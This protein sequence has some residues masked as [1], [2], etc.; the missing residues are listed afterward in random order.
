MV[1][2]IFAY[3]C[4]AV[5]FFSS[6]KKD[7]SSVFSKPPQERVAETLTALDKTLTSGDGWVM[8]VFTQLN[9][10]GYSFYC[11]FKD[12]NRVNMLSD[13][14][15]QTVTVIKQ[16]SYRT[17]WMQQPSLIFDTYNYL[18]LLSDPMPSEGNVGGSAG[19]GLV[20]DF[21]F[22]L[23]AETVDSL[24]NFPDKLTQLITIGRYNQLNVRF[25]KLSAASADF[26][27]QGKMKDFIADVQSFIESHAVNGVVLSSNKMQMDFGD[28][29]I[30]FTW[31]EGDSVKSKGMGFAYGDNKIVLED[32]I[33]FGGEKFTQFIWDS[34]KLY[35]VSTTNSVQVV[36]LGAPIIPV[37]LAIDKGVIEEIDVLT[38][39]ATFPGWGSD[40]ITRRSQVAQS[41]TGWN[42]SGSKLSLGY[43]GIVFDAQDTTAQIVIQ[44]PYGTNSALYLRYNYKYTKT[45]DG[46]ITFAFVSGADG[47]ATAI[48]STFAPL[49]SQRIETDHFKLDYYVASGTILVRFTSVEHPDFVFTGYPG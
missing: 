48:Y 3:I 28:K 7:D 10:Q 9:D 19:Q 39:Y 27:R 26:W 41:I 13:L 25:Y 29:N 8:Y 45:S 42:V 23:T 35:L 32:T 34:Q 36:D 20:S 4:L 40:F 2:R 21:S 43:M 17:Q 12:S 22:G 6:C 16:S 44:T 18:H 14:N 30:K 47:N 38:N 49:L 24:N 31:M 33:N 5:A 37:S 11:Q 1:K 46:I 15:D